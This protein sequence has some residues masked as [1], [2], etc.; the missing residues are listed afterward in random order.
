MQPQPSETTPE[1]PTWARMRGESAKA[2]E[3]FRRYR[4]A[5]PHRSLLGCRSIERRW[6]WRWHWAEHRRR[7]GQR[8]VAT[9]P[10]RRRSPPLPAEQ[11]ARA[12]GRRAAPELDRGEPWATVLRELTA[13]A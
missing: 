1:R 3:A 8:A 9:L 10:T 6:S 13:Q 5:G 4:D 11:A 12:R 2:Y 7:V